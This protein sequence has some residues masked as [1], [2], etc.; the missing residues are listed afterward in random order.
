MESHIHEIVWMVEGKILSARNNHAVRIFRDNDCLSDGHRD[1]FRIREIVAEAFNALVYCFNKDDGRIPLTS[2]MMRI[3]RIVARILKLKNAAKSTQLQLGGLIVDEMI[4]AGYLILDKEVF[5]T[6]QKVTI[7]KEKLQKR[8]GN[9]TLSI[10]EHLQGFDPIHKQTIF[11]KK[12]V[13]WEADTRAN[14]RY[15]EYLVSN[16]GDDVNV[17]KDEAYVK[18]I[19]NLEAVKWQVNHK[20]AQVSKEL[21]EN[22]MDNTIILD[23]GIKFDV[24]DINREKANKHLA[25]KEL[26]FNGQIFNPHK[27]NQRATENRE[28]E[29]NKLNSYMNRLVKGGKLHTK[30]VAIYKR[31]SEAFDKVSNEWAAKKY[32][33]GQQS[34][35][36]RNTA[37]LNT[38]HGENGWLTYQFYLPMYLDFRGRMYARNPYFSYQSSDL[39]RGHLVFAQEKLMTDKGYRWLLL[40]AANSFNQS[41][42]VAELSELDWLE[43]NYIPDLVQDDVPDLSVDKMSLNDRV[44]WAEEN[45]D[46]I[47]DISDDPIKHKAIWLGAEKPWVFLSLCFEIAGYW[48]SLGNGEDYYSRLPIAID[49]ASNGTQHLAAMSRD[50]KAG[51]M[52]G[53]V[54][55][56]KPVDFYVEVAKGIIKCNIDTDLKDVLAAIPM[57]LI[58]K[59]ISKRGT[60]TR[61]YDAGV[62]CISEIIYDDCYSA[63][64]TVKYGITKN[65][66]FRLA[67][68]LVDTYSELCF[69]PVAVKIYLQ[70]LVKYQMTVNKEDHISWLTPSGFP[71]LS[72]KMIFRTISVKTYIQGKRLALIVREDLDKPLISDIISGISPNYVHSMDASHMALVINELHELGIKSFGAIHDSFSVHAE[73]IDQLLL[74]T[75]YNFIDM[76]RDCIYQS[77]AD[78]LTNGTFKPDI[79]ELYKGDLILEDLVDSDYFFC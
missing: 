73:D 54:K 58:R 41:Y 35:I 68:N 1:D 20:V 21:G 14:G 29:L 6:V 36:F 13:P 56:E 50:D 49:G 43:V 65:M 5:Y 24:F 57:K 33:L 2:T 30:S 37:I 71:V 18:A 11:W 25:G 62:K 59:G 77:M 27:G 47:I 53:L 52:V 69:G 72:K 23:R 39:A 74:A 32:C 26:F 17:D 10:G 78:H 19:N 42:T 63:G 3:G 15:R 7:G 61:A 34:K 9:Y 75:K 8:F 12:P 48:E 67:R 4:T 76:Y 70:E 31:R 46:M 28:K 40:H 66:A 38:I 44:M 55:S 60:M 64:M 79:K 16:R 45:L 51:A 22:I